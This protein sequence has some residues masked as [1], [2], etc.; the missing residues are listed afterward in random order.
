MKTIGSKFRANLF[1]VIFVKFFW[2]NSHHLALEM[3]DD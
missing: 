1:V 3:N 2:M